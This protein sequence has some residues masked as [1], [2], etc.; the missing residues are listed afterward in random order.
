VFA[1]DFPPPASDGDRA[2][3]SAQQGGAAI[4][5]APGRGQ[6]EVI[7]ADL[8]S[9]FQPM[10]PAGWLRRVARAGGDGSILAPVQAVL[11]QVPQVGAG[12]KI[13]FSGEVDGRRRG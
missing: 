9:Y 10:S 3:K 7:A 8:S 13:V 5:A 1:A 2:G 6:S 11:T 12:L 4:R